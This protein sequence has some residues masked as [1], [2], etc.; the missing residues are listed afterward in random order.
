MSSYINEK[1]GQLEIDFNNNQDTDTDS[2]SDTDNDNDND[3][4]NDSESEN[5]ITNEHPSSE[6]SIHNEDSDTDDDVTNELEFQAQIEE[7]MNLSMK[8]FEENK[9]QIEKDLYDNLNISTTQF[10][11]V[12]YIFIPVMPLSMYSE[13]E[14]I[15]YLENT[16]KCIAPTIIF[17][18]L[19]LDYTDSKIKLKIYKDDTY[20][21]LKVY[22][23]DFIIDDNIYIPCTIFQKLEIEPGDY[24]MFKTY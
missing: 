6:N 13:Y 11:N 22:P 16:K 15:K 19:L 21:N 3:N 8:E 4:D 10:N 5:Y 17:N 9:T 1:L 7:M 14:N 2:D 12:D 18:N 20:T 23:I 24:L